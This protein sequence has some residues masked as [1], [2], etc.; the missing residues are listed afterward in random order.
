MIL[1]SMVGQYALHITKHRNSEQ[2]QYKVH[3]T[4]MFATT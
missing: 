3:H 1:A 2:A 4:R